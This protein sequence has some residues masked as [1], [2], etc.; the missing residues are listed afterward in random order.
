[1]KVRTK[2]I[3]D[4]GVSYMAL[5]GLKGKHTLPQ[6][7]NGRPDMIERIICIFYG[8]A[9]EQIYSKRRD[10]DIV[11]CRHLSMYFIRRYTKMSLKSIGERFGR[12]HTTVI[13]AIGSVVKF[14]DIEEDY[15]KEVICIEEKINENKN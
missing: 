5:V 15:R 3:L 8:I 7:R 11:T 6:L 12:D 13:H 14:M 2:K 10:R 9:I 4:T 1:M